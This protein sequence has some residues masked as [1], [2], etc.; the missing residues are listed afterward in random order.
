M[1]TLDDYYNALNRLIENKPI[2]IP[3]NSKINNDSVALEAGRKRGSIKKS[4]PVFNDL[5]GLINK[6]QNTSNFE[7]EQLKKLTKKYRLKSDEYK[8]LYEKALNRELL[9]IEELKNL[10]T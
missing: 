3:K 2:H 6:A 8:K 10:K 4:R 1:D 5:I 9:L 7:I